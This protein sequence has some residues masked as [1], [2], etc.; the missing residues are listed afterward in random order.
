ML[1]REIMDAYGQFDIIV[2]H[3]AEETLPPLLAKLETRGFNGIPGVTW[4]DGRNRLKITPGLPKIEDLDSLPIPAYELYPVA[5]LGLDLMRVEAGRGCPFVCT[6]CS[7]SSFFQRD[8]RLKS[9]E[10]IVHEMD[11][12]HARYGATEFKLDHDLFTV[13]RRKVREFCDAVEDRGYSWRVSARTDCVDA[14]LLEKMALAGCI[15]LYFG[16]ET[17]SQR[18]QRLADKRLRLDGV[19]AILDVAEHFGIETT[20]SFI[21]G[22][23]DELQDD[24]D[25]TLDMLGA[26]F[27]RPQD[28]CTPQLHILLPEPGT[29]MFTKHGK[30]LA[31][32]GYVTKFNARL[33]HDDRAEVLAHPELYSTYFYYPAAIQRQCHVLAVDAVDAFRAVGHQIL[34]YA[35][36]FYQNRLSV[37]IAA[38]GDWVASTGASAVTAD[39]ALE[40][41]TAQFGASHHLTSLFRYGLALRALTQAGTA[42]QPEVEDALSG[43]RELYA[44]SP[45]SRILADLHDCGALL[46]RISALPATA[47]PLG[48]TDAGQRACYLMVVQLRQATLYGVDPDLEVILELFGRPQR[49]TDVIELLHDIAGDTE[50]DDH[51]LDRLVDIGALVRHAVRP[52]PLHA[53]S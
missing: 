24:Q 38:F 21:T 35:L 44:L 17:G 33:F 7:T 50:L 46:E 6:F 47:G 30:S 51:L 52:A 27:A 37:L 31:Y 45:G 40:F 34:T 39:L 4:R 15:G 42:L 11:L 9:A 19:D 23:P 16:I 8:Y 25:A 13:N 29:P 2:R 26:C 10:R 18:M 43:R 22:Y 36:R 48:A 49:L 14:S 32:D 3:E 1:H 53:A 12:L 5:T 20:A 28:A 41:I